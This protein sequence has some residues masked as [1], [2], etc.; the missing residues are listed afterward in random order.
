[1]AAHGRVGQEQLVE[2]A[3][4]PGREVPARP[5]AP[6][7]GVDL[8]HH[9]VELGELGTL[10]RVGAHRS[11]VGFLQHGGG[12]AEGFHDLHPALAEFSGRADDHAVARGKQIRH[13]MSSVR[14]ACP[15][16]HC[17]R[18]CIRT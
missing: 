11:A 9:V 10:L 15:D 5:P 4:E 7:L 12:Q 3:L 14:P 6:H 17:G 18:T 8:G 2:V 16:R 1:M 13:R